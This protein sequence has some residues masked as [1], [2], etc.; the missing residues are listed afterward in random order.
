MITLKDN[1]NKFNKRGEGEE[2][3]Y[4]FF[5]VP[6]TAIVLI[7]LISSTQSI[8]TKLSSTNNLEYY[9]YSKRA[10]NALSYG[11]EGTGRLYPGIID[12][13]R[14]NDEILKKEFDK[15]GYNGMEFGM[16]LTLIYLNEIKPEQEIYYDKE[17]YDISKAFYSI[18]KEIYVLVKSG[19]VL[20]PAKLNID[21]AYH[22]KRYPD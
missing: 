18:Q 10:V 22:L 8:L 13:L 1:M 20:K 2:L 6:L 11:D 21:L 16:K 14:W 3:I 17:N 19:D 15:E 4:W 5:Y 9:I 7:I 12:I